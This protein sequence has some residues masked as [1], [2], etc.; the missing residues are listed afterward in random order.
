MEDT[1]RYKDV[2]AQIITCNSEMLSIFEYIE[3]LA[4]TDHPVLITGE[5]G[6]GKELI[7]RSIHAVRGRQGRL[8]AINGSSFDDSVFTEI[9]FGKTEEDGSFRHGMIEEAAN[10]TLFLDEIGL[11]GPVSQADLLDFLDEEYLPPDK[12]HPKP[13]NIDFL[14]ATSTDLWGLQRT[15]RFRKELNFKLRA[16]HIHVPSLRERPEDI[17]LLVNFFLNEAARTL[18]KKRPTPPKELF[19]LLKTYS[20]PGNVRE[21][22]DMVFEAVNRHKSKVLSLDV[23]KSCIDREHRGYRIITDLDPDENSPFKSLRELPTIKGITR[24]L[25]HEAMRRANGNQ[26]I[27]ARMLGISQPALSKRLKKEA[28]LAEKNVK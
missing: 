6:V 15:G 16:H 12:K 9:L 11:L 14:A 5:N 19:T 25:V 4:G 26:S 1:L 3:S 13:V 22:R 8:L 27:A 10:G 2:F 7:A 17:P 23:F 18:R 21:L 20:F 24:L 28:E